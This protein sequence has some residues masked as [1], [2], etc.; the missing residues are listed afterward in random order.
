MKTAK[1]LINDHLRSAS[2]DESAASDATA[3]LRQVV[4]DLNK[5][6]REN[7]GKNVFKKSGIKVKDIIDAIKKFG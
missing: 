3:S 2:L 1:G 6:S 7:P 4:D 5:A